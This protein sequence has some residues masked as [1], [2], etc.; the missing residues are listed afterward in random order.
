MSAFPSQI[1]TSIV[2]GTAR[3]LSG[4]LS[5]LQR[6]LAAIEHEHEAA[7]QHRGQPTSLL[8]QQ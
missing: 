4:C 5:V 2:A 6:N 8:S 1:L 3:F 7:V